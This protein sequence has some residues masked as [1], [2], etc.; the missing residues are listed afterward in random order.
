MKVSWFLNEPQQDREKALEQYWTSIQGETMDMSNIHDGVSMMK[1]FVDY[2]EWKRTK[3]ES[4]LYIPTGPT[5]QP[6]V[7]F[8]WTTKTTR[9]VATPI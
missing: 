1:R 7:N 2:V 4:R 6:G 9:H 8:L 5:I 3:H